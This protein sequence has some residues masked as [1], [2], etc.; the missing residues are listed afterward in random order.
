M[1]LCSLSWEIVHDMRGAVATTVLTYVAYIGMTWDGIHLTRTISRSHTRNRDV[2]ENKSENFKK[3]SMT[4]TDGYISGMQHLRF[5]SEKE[6]ENS[7][8]RFGSIR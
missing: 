1:S 2:G 6:L 3:N 5:F 4:Q 7:G 8:G